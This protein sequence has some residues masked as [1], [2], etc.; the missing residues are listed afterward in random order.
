MQGFASA[1]PQISRYFPVDRE[2]E[3]LP[4]QYIAN[5]IYTIAGNAF[6]KWVEAQMRKRND[7]IKAE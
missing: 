7:K 2:M 4:R 5:V 3:K 1:Y 6:A